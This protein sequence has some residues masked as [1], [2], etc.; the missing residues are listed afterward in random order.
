MGWEQ[1]V[2]LSLFIPTNC[3]LVVKIS[4]NKYIPSIQ[5]AERRD[6]DLLL[7]LLKTLH[8]DGLNM[9]HPDMAPC[10]ISATCRAVRV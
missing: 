1:G 8:H 7:Y 9:Q 6:R 3:S 5:K 2:S 10:M 4:V